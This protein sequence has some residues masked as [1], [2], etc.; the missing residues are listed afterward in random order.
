MVMAMLKLV[1]S[2]KFKLNI[3][4]LALGWGIPTHDYILKAHMNERTLFKNVIANMISQPSEVNKSRL[5]VP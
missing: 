3:S 5:L 1:Y 4:L 2:C